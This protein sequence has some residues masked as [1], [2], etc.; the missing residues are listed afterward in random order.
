MGK[1]SEELVKR[2]EFEGVE[3]T[4][5]NWK[6]EWCYID[7]ELSEY[8][9]Y[10]KINDMT[11]YINNKY[12]FKVKTKEWNE[13]KM[14]NSLNDLFYCKRKGFYLISEAGVLELVK[15]IRKTS[16]SIEKLTEFA[17]RLTGV[18]LENINIPC[19]EVI[20]F[21]RLLKEL[22]WLKEDCLE[23]IGSIYKMDDATEE[24]NKRVLEENRKI[25]INPQFQYSA[26]DNKY[27]I[28]CYFED[29]RLAI[30]YDEK[31]HNYRQ[32]EDREREL[33]ISRYFHDLYELDEE[34]YEDMKNDG[35]NDVNEYLFVDERKERDNYVKFMRVKE[36]EEDRMIQKIKMYLLRYLFY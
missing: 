33:A 29:I 15:K 3:F 12:L 27:K 32:K 19:K 34:F 18:R 2:V 4:V 25:I 21:D 9:E 30:E 24:D 11:R 31:Y 22:E 20:F 16:H 1:Q 10:S 23:V 7:K 26:C 13:F 6:G 36:G 14:N 17:Y 8:L 28:D 5:V 35:Y